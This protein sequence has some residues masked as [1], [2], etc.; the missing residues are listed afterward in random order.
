[1]IT[2]VKCGRERPNQSLLK[3][4]FNKGLSKTGL[5]RECYLEVRRNRKF[6]VRKQWL[7][8]DGYLEVAIPHSHRFFGMASQSRQTVLVHRLVMAEYLDR[9]LASGEIVHHINGVK[10]D[11]R[12]ENLSLTTKSG[13]A[14]SYQDGYRK[15]IKEGIEL[16]DKE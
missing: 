16:R 7:T 4:Q 1:M 5:C 9:L 6:E 11:N 8:S 3:W 10:T 15:G 13:H 14:L 2:C 12:I